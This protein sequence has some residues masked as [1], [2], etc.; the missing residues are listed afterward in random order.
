M[1]NVN[2]LLAKHYSKTISEKER[3]E[4]HKLLKKKYLF[5]ESMP[6]YHCLQCGRPLK[7]S[8]AWGPA[9]VWANGGCGSQL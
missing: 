4:L 9:C 3:A 8:W 7:F 1:S 6:E 2:E 5:G